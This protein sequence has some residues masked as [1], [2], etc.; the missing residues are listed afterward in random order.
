M[1]AEQKYDFKHNSSQVASK[2]C[3]CLQV[4]NGYKSNRK[5][6]TILSVH[7]LEKSWILLEKDDIGFK[8]IMCLDM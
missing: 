1:K 7:M 6:Y 3:R 4:K 5:G 2:N 8:E